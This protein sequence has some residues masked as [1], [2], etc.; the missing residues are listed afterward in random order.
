MQDARLSV[1]VAM[2]RYERLDDAQVQRFRRHE[3]A[4][5]FSL[6]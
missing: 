6:R 4:L 5:D 1:V 3:K 2:R